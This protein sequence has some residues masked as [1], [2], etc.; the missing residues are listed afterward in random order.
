[1]EALA[2]MEADEA[3]AIT[4]PT[5]QETTPMAVLACEASPI[6]LSET[7]KSMMAESQ[8]AMA[9]RGEKSQEKEATIYTDLTK[10]AI[11][12]ERLV[13]KAKFCAEDNGIMS[14][15]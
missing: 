8:N 12:I 2:I 10:R 14:P 13:T 5:G 7:L 4:A 6:V 15:T 3:T 1:M 11:E 9:K